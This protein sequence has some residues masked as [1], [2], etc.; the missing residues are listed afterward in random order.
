MKKYNPLPEIALLT[1]PILC[2]SYFGYT[3]Y[4]ESNP[5]AIHEAQHVWV[6]RNSVIKPAPYPQNATV[7][8]VPFDKYR[9]SMTSQTNYIHFGQSGVN[10][11]SVQG[12]VILETEDSYHY[13]SSGENFL[14][15]HKSH[16]KELTFLQEKEVV[17]WKADRRWLSLVAFSL[18]CGFIAGMLLNVVAVILFEL[19]RIGACPYPKG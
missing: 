15:F 2:S 9:L 6:P 3:G 7:V 16:K 10:Y 18:I 17:Q 8:R 12:K 11:Q 5:Q 13:S 19:L 14:C 4:V 1:L